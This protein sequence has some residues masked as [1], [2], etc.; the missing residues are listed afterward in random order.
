MAA[1]SW[2]WNEHLVPLAEAWDSGA[3]NW[4]KAQRVAY[5]NDLSVD[6]HLVAV[7]ARSNRQKADRDVA[8]WLPPVE[9]VRCRYITEWIAVKTRYGLSVD[10]AEKDTLTQYASTC[11]NAPLA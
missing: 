4:D 3:R 2:A 9:A 8:E 10:Q 11:T 1:C 6:H 5:A 7:T